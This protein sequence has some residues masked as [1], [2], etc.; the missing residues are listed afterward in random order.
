[1]HW[2]KPGQ[3]QSNMINSDMMGWRHSHSLINL[4]VLHRPAFAG[5]SVAKRRPLGGSTASPVF[6]EFPW[7]I[8]SYSNCHF[9]DGFHH[10]LTVWTCLN[11]GQIIEII[12]PITWSN[13]HIELYIVHY[14]PNESSNSAISTKLSQSQIQDAGLKHRPLQGGVRLPSL[15]VLMLTTVQVK[16]N[17]QVDWVVG[18]LRSKDSNDSISRV[19]KIDSTILRCF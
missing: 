6:Q 5:I 9:T 15:M 8:T 17:C 11:R 4:R 3:N 1:M 2:S 14:S 13:Q 12:L 18:S 10:C 7:P 16:Q 19:F